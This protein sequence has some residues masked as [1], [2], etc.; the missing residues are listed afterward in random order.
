MAPLRPDPSDLNERFDRIDRRFEQIDQRLD[1]LSE[2]FNQRFDRALLV[3]V[4]GHA[5][6]L[7]AIFLN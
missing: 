7:A 1:R 6:L 3:Q 5:T 4:G 2:L